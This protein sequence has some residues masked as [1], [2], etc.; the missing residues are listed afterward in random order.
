M[1]IQDSRLRLVSGWDSTWRGW[2]THVR[3]D[4]NPVMSCCQK[5]S[6]T[7]PDDAVG[8]PPKRPKLCAPT[9]LVKLAYPPSAVIDGTVGLPML[10]LMRI[11]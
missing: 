2:V 7:M 5:K 11:P 10:V 1:M 9:S 8:L 3:I 6:E 4:E